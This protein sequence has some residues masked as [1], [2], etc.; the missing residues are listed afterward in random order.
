MLQF[1]VGISLVGIISGLI[2]L[3]GL[4]AGEPYGVWT[5]IFLI[6]TI[7][8]SATGFP[9]PPYGFDPP[10]VVGVISLVLLAIA[11]GAYYAFG[12]AGAWRWIYV[13]SAVAALYL[14]VF[15]GVAQ[16][17]Q[18]IPDLKKL[19]PTQKEPPFVVTQVVVL[20]AFVA[21]GAW[22]VI[23]FQPDIGLRG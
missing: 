1:H 11:V 18:K 16:A 21:L 2:V 5:A 6:T 13:V 9:L 8:T 4:I 10:R 7:L 23:N 3:Y 20:L 19:A 14:N 22:A 12:L 17:F 15:V